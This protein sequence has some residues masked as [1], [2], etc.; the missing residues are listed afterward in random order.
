MSLRPLRPAPACRYRRTRT[1]PAR[2][3]QGPESQTCYEYDL[4]PSLVS[5]WF[6]SAESR[7]AAARL[8]HHSLPKRLGMRVEEQALV[9]PEDVPAMSPDF[10]FELPRR[11]S[12]VTNKDAEIGSGLVVQSA[13]DGGIR[14]QQ[15]EISGDPQRGARRLRFRSLEH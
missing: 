6:S 13:E 3:V 9:V 14:R 5:I 11:P 10:A 15:I 4:K 2:A 8:F 1:P 7:E 12:G